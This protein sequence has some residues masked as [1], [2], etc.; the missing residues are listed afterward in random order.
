MM[1]RVRLRFI[2]RIKKKESDNWIQRILKNGLSIILLPLIIVLGLLIMFFG[3]IIS[4]FQKQDKADSSD[5]KAFEEPW[6]I[7]TEINGVTIW[8]RYRG[9]VRFGPGYY[10]LKTEPTIPEVENKLFGDW[11]Y[12][13]GQGIFLQQWNNTN[14]PDTTLVY[15]DSRDKKSKKLKTQLIRFSGT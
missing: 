4:V 5:H 8:R 9:E 15:F 13:H 6:T 14:K 2:S 7:F 1:E 11:L 12:R 3:L 10:E